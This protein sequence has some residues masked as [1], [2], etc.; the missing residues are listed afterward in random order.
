MQ[1]DFFKSFTDFPRFTVASVKVILLLM[2]AQR[3]A[4]IAVTNHSES[5]WGIH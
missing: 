5:S 2:S 1:I 3:F 4:S